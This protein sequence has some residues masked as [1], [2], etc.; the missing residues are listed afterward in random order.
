MIG[1]EKRPQE[2]VLIAAVA[3]GSFLFIAG[4]YGWHGGW[5]FGPRYLVPMLPFLAFPIAFLRWRP[6][7]FW[8]LF[9][10]SCA[11]VVL[12]V[13]GVP[14]VPEHIANPIVEFIVP[15]MGYGYTALNAGMLLSLDWPW[16][17]TA[18]VVLVGLFGVWA[19]RESGRDKPTL[20]ADRVPVLSVAVLIIWIG[21]IVAVLVMIR[22]DQ[23]AMVQ[24]LRSRVLADAAR[25]YQSPILERA[26]A[27]EAIA[28]YLAAIK[29]NPDHFEAHC[30]LA[31]AFVK[32]SKLD[33]AIEH[34][35]EAVRINPSSFAALNDL[36]ANLERQL[37]HE[38]AIYYY[39]QALLIEP[40]NPGIHFNLGVALGNKGKLKEAIEH[41]SQAIN[42]RPD[43]GEAHQAL[44]LAQELKRQ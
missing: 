24:H 19:F 41:F 42:I 31:G 11:Q 8:L 2:A 20:C 25:I 4:F 6:Y 33:Q 28:H 44:K 3:I 14:H 26:A 27:E 40:K 7:I 9:V 18:A 23:P 12:S 21:T 16:S 39:R 22:T 1:R 36:G 38:E 37:K 32:Q 34:L 5:T 13:I 10:P 15:C 17:V 35:R 29:I 43:Y 30:N